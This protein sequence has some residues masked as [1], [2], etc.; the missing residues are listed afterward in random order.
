VA[1][2]AASLLA[3]HDHPRFM[4]EIRPVLRADIS[5]RSTDH[6]SLE[7]FVQVSRRLIAFHDL[8]SMR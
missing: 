7:H 5:L 1:A 6:V 8:C 3:K 2:I 4:T